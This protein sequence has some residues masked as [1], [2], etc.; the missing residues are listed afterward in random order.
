[1]PVITSRQ[2]I[3]GIRNRQ[4]QTIMEMKG[5]A[6]LCRVLPAPAEARS[7]ETSEYMLFVLRPV[8]NFNG[9]KHRF[10]FVNQSALATKLSATKV[11]GNRWR[12][13][14]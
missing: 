10:V 3:F 9:T 12:R 14:A 8:G 5:R 2:P 7:S 4:S 6:S 11:G 13:E 1:M